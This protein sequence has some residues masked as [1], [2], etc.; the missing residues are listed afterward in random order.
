MPEDVATLRLRLGVERGTADVVP[1][2]T[3]VVNNQ[4]RDLGSQ[5][6]FALLDEELPKLGVEGGEYG[7]EERLFFRYFYSREWFGT[8]SE[9]L[10]GKIGFPITL[11]DG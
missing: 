7:G 5:F 8:A 3:S 2:A 6:G 1:A 11:S 4:G 10:R 9:H